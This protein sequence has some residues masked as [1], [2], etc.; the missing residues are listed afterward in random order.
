MS[1]TKSKSKTVQV[2]DQQARVSPE[3]FDRVS[4]YVWTTQRRGR[5]EKRVVITRVVQP[6]VPGEK[7]PRK[8]I[9]AMHRLITGVPDGIR[10][11]HAD[12]NP[13]NNQRGNLLVHKQWP[14]APY[15]WGFDG[16]KWESYYLIPGE[17]DRQL[18]AQYDDEL[19]ALMAC[20]MRVIEQQGERDPVWLPLKVLRRTRA[21]DPGKWEKLWPSFVSRQEDDEDNGA[22]DII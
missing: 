17:N 19:D 15:E 18:L 5:S 8:K 7:K 13:S 12:G 16:R 10:V 14:N 11:T 4:A 2:G 9:L 1:A 6:L 20:A 21:H 3:D 22:G